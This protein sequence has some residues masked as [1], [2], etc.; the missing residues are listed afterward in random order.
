MSLD[1][2]RK[3]IDA[4][5]ADLIRLLNQRTEVVLEIGK[6]KRSKGEDAGMHDHRAM[7]REQFVPGFKLG[8]IPTD[9]RQRLQKGIAL[10][11][12]FGISRKMSRVAWLHL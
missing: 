5:D 8:F 3:K 6:L 10:G 4:M 12:S 11:E 1:D 9:F 7:P 2:L